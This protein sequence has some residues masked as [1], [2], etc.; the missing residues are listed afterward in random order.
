MNNDRSFNDRF[1]RVLVND[2]IHAIE[3]YDGND[4]ETTRRDLVRTT[5]AAV[6]GVTWDYQ[7]F[8]WRVA[9]DI[10]PL[11]P[12]MELAFGQKSYT[13]DEKGHLQEV[14]RFIPIPAMIRLT[15]RLACEL[16]P[17][18][19]IDFGEQG[20]SDLKLAIKVRNRITH[21]KNLTDLKISDG[22][23]SMCYSGFFWLLSSVIIAMEATTGALSDYLKEITFITEKLKNGDEE[24]LRLYRI[25]MQSG[26]N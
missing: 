17:E 11:S 1:L 26:E 6:E 19:L 22:D 12:I 4:T 20:W 23:I 15:T 21:P 3:R 2:V 10:A 9:N 13:V 18:L 14:T 24:M 8:I 25:E 5:F 7:Q 16:C